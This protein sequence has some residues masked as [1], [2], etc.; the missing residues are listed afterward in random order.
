MRPAPIE[1]SSATGLDALVRMM[2]EQ[3]RGSVVVVDDGRLAGIL[4][5]RDVMRA[6]AS[7]VDPAAVS[8]GQWM[9]AEPITVTP[10]TT[11]A[12][13][14]TLMCE[15]GVHHLPVVDGGR[16]VGMVGLRDVTRALRHGETVS[17]GLGF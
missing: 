11:L 17:V 13:A 6:V 1:V 3:D 12:V 7:S 9:T 4:T 10:S 14:E 2:R 15:Y 8:A 5:A 16:V